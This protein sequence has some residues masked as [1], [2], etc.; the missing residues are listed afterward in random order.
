[1]P[2]SGTT[3]CFVLGLSSVCLFDNDFGGV[4]IKFTLDPVSD[5][6]QLIIA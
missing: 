1:L 5:R 2:L 6:Q 4:P 3:G